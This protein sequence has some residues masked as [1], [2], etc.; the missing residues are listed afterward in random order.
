MA[1]YVDKS[2]KGYCKASNLAFNEKVR[3]QSAALNR[4]N[5]TLLHAKWIQIKE[6]RAA[7][8]EVCHLAFGQS[9]FPIPRPFVEELKDAA[10]VNDY[11]SVAGGCIQ[12]I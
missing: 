1:Q 10:H 2:L 11:L 3:Y 6:M 4:A 9:P 8:E 12:E 7:G 5:F